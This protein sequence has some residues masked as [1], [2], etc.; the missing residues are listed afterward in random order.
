M[1]VCLFPVNAKTTAQIDAKR[2]EIT[3][4]DPESVL[5]GL[6]SSVLVFLG[7][8]RDIYNLFVRGRPPFYL[9]PFYFQLLP[10][11]D[12]FNT[13]RFRQNGVYRAPHRYW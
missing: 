5:C 11:L 6:K 13:E 3:K 12:P 2:S 1:F 7:K 10:R 4:N 8:Y 9:S